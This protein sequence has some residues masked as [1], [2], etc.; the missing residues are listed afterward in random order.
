[1]PEK[2]PPIPGDFPLRMRT[3]LEILS[4]GGSTADCLRETG[5]KSASTISRWRSRPD[6]RAALE[7]R[8]TGRETALRVARQIA[9]NPGATDMARA[10]AC[11][12]LLISAPRKHH[13]VEGRRLGKKFRRN[14]QRRKRAQEHE[15]RQLLSDALG[16]PQPEPPP[17][18]FLTGGPTGSP[19]RPPM[20]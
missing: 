14:E 17:R 6:F 13:A 11:E 10:K 9:E 3:A 12:L 16:E 7:E 4:A 8:L 19:N 1:M 18:P 20:P 15:Y 2:L 5:L